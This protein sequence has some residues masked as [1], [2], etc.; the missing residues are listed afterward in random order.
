MHTNRSTFGR[1]REEGEGSTSRAPL[2]KLSFPEFSGDNPRIWIDKCLDY[3][4]IFNIPESMWTTAASL[5]MEDN[6]AKWLQVY[7]LKFGLDSRTEFVVAV[8]TKLGAFDYRRAIQDLL[9]IRQE[10]TV[11]E[12]TK[13]F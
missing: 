8:E 11:E 7:K 6:T 10:G 5:N 13:N 1:N 4:K 9:A 12:Y 3:F 2:P